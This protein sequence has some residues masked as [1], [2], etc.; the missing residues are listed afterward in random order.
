[1]QWNDNQDLLLERPLQ[2]NETVD[3]FHYTVLIKGV[4]DQHFLLESISSAIEQNSQF[5]FILPS[6]TDH[7]LHLYH[8]DDSLCDLIESSS[9]GIFIVSR[10]IARRLVAIK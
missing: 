7:N 8:S 5:S 4:F 1:M 2:N 9:Y 10:P 3:D 6:Q